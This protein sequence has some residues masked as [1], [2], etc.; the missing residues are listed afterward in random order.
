M[1]TYGFQFL[2][3]FNLSFQLVQLSASTRDRGADQAL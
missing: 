2:M 3:G 1:G